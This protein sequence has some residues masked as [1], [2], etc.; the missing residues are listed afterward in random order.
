MKLGCSSDSSSGRLGAILPKKI[1]E[2][3][4]AFLLGVRWKALST[5][6]KQLATSNWQLAQL[7]PTLGNTLGGRL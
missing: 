7:K 6:A 3:C 2:R 1:F 4:K 5:Q